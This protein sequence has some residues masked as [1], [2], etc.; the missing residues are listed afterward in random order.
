[1]IMETERE[2]S[3][4]FRIYDATTGEL[5]YRLFHGLTVAD[6]EG[7]ASDIVDDSSSTYVIIYKYHKM[8]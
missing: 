3:W 6:A 8:F 5:N 7:L 1:M 2:Y 4:V